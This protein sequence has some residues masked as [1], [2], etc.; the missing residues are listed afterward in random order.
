MSIIQRVPWTVQPQS[1]ARPNYGSPLASGLQILVDS[2]GYDAT[3]GA[4][5]ARS[6]TLDRRPTNKGVG[7]GSGGS[8]YFTNAS[9]VDRRYVC[10]NNTSF[11]IIGTIAS[12]NLA[13]TNTYLAFIR[14]G[15]GTGNQAAV[16]YEFVNNTVEFYAPAFT[17][18]DPRT[19]SGIVIPDTAAHTFGYSYDG[20][21]Y[22][23]WLDG[24]LVFS[25]TRTFNCNVAS[26]GLI[27]SILS[28]G[29]SNTTQTN[30]LQWATFSAGKTG[31]EMAALTA[32][33]WQLFA[34]LQ[35]RIWAPPAA[36]GAYTVTADVAAY[37]LA[38]Q[39]AALVKSRIVV[40]DA[41]AYSLAGQDASLLVGHRVIADAAAYALAAQDAILLRGR[42]V[43]A[44]A[45]AYV[46]AGQDATLTYTPSGT[47]YTLTCDAA[48][49]AIAGQDA[50]L[51]R[52]RVVAAES[53]AYS[54][55]GQDATLSFSGAQQQKLGGVPAWNP[56]EKRGETEEQ[57]RTRRIAQG[58]IREA[59]KPAADLEKLSK[60]ASKVSGLL[61]ADAARYEADAARYATEIAQSKLAI[62]QVMMAR[63]DAL[64]TRQLEQ[65]MIA[66]QLQAEFAR[67]M[68]QELDVVFMAVMLAAIED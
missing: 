65:R 19:G 51:I 62:A 7:I 44:D 40:A 2:F 45:A 1:P 4:L 30:L 47:T 31:P 35:R 6:G 13:Q 48:S 12:R 67:Q 28:A 16:I 52:G 50:N 39:D 15:G 33:P 66:A 29:G 34:P 54:F 11:T 63:N 21:N 43:T 53:G 3:S 46:L 10:V 22:S 32:N 26:T 9:T 36:G 41:A 49:F 57:K 68:V 42:V 37:I 17:G 58:I 56:Y 18:S 20:S 24:A 14:D 64:A 61:Q 55:T 38:A 27:S 25:T 60:K 8:A 23:G 59:Q 5:L